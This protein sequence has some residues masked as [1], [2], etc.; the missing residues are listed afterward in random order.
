MSLPEELWYIVFDHLPHRSILEFRRV[1]TDFRIAVNNFLQSRKHSAIQKSAFGESLSK[2]LGNNSYFLDWNLLFHR[3]RER[4]RHEIERNIPTF[5]RNNT[6]SSGEILRSVDRDVAECAGRSLGG[7]IYE[8]TI[9]SLALDLLTR[10]ENY[11]PSYERTIKWALSTNAACN[12]RVLCD[13]SQ[14][15][16]WTDCKVYIETIYNYFVDKSKRCLDDMDMNELHRSLNKASEIS[17]EKFIEIT[18]RVGLIAY[19]ISRYELVKYLWE[20]RLI[21]TFLTRDHA[22]RISLK[23]HG[24]SNNQ[25]ME[26]VRGFLSSSVINEATP[27]RDRFENLIQNRILV[28]RF[29]D[30]KPGVMAFFWYEPRGESSN[31]VHALENTFQRP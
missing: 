5:H 23:N 26:I 9:T 15:V 7:L 30:S 29:S 11:D 1:S 19:R 31:P 12:Y 14:M 3:L 4:L 17:K 27:E 10:Q 8:E 24:I 22:E 13:Q 28:V 16:N 25:I 21:P 18:N 6:S 2:R 20:K